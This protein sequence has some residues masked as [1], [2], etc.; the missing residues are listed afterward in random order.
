LAAEAALLALLLAGAVQVVS[1]TPCPTAAAVEARLPALA[2]TPS[3]AP[4]RALIRGSE[5]KV[6]LTLVRADGTAVVERQIEAPG[7]CPDLA[8]AAALII[9]VWQAQEHP[10]LPPAPTLVSHPARLTVEAKTDL[11]ASLAGAEVSPG[12]TL[13]AVL[14]RRRWGLALSLSGTAQHEGALGAGRATWTRGALGLGVARRLVAGWARLDLHVEALLGLTVARGSGY[15]SDAAPVGSTFGGG[16][17]M[18]VSHVWGRLLVSAG[19]SG[20]R[21]LAQDL[22][23]SVSGDRRALPVTEARAGAGLG[24][25]FDL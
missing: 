4:D 8:G 24:L 7:S 19:A 15:Q 16:A 22:A 9:A 14:W 18:T 20:A 12:A 17:G 10:D 2:P 23:V 13:T 5:G 25:R 1:T 21:W 11:F 3:G 6:T